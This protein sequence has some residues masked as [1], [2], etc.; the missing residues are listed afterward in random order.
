MLAAVPVRYEDTEDSQLD[1]KA[2]V[3]VLQHSALRDDK[4]ISTI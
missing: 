2:Q 3:Y 1:S 4:A